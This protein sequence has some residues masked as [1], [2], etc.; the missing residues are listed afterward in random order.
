MKQLT[1]FN[2]DEVHDTI[3]SGQNNVFFVVKNNTNADKRQRG[4]RSNFS[5]DCGVYN[6]AN[7]YT[8]KTYL[9]ADTEGKQVFYKKGD[10]F[11]YSKKVKS[12]KT[13]VPFENQPTLDSVHEFARNYST[14]K[15]DSSFKRRVSWLGDSHIA[16]EKY[17]P[18]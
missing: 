16:L 1:S 13:F 2:Y 12:N 15:K 10:S 14:L 17:F 3:P 4:I 7:G 9:T 18:D 11:C 5:D 6:S 8:P